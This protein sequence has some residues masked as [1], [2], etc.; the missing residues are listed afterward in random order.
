M[1]IQILCKRI[2]EDNWFPTTNRPGFHST[3]QDSNLLL[4]QW[5]P[6]DYANQSLVQKQI[7]TQKDLINGRF[8]DWR[9]APVDWMGYNPDIHDYQIRGSCRRWI[10]KCLNARGRART[11]NAL[12]VNSAFNDALEHGSAILAAS[13]HDYRNIEADVEFYRYLIEE[14]RSKYPNVNIRY[15]GAE[16]A[17]RLHLKIQNVKDYIS[18]T[19]VLEINLSNNILN[20]KLIKGKI[21]GSQPFLAIKTINDLY[22]NDNF[23]EIKNNS[24]WQYIFDENTLLI[25]SIKFIGGGCAGLFGGFDVKKLCLH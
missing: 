25:K 15:M 14:C 3:R 4:E 16:S 17:A 12:E 13:S 18:E 21:M 7:T 19:P 10:F 8:G 22:Y 2:I 6:F 5:I 20:V 9:R 11:I 24:E 23:D 1:F